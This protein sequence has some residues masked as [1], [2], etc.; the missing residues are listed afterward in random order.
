ML[1]GRLVD[2]GVVIVNLP[3]GLQSPPIRYT[4]GSLS[5]QWRSLVSPFLTR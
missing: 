4:L 2:G 1:P 3:A 5:E